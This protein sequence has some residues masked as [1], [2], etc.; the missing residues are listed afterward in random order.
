MS[1]YR[2]IVREVEA[3]RV[4]EAG[5]CQTLHGPISYE[6]VDYLIEDPVTKDR[7]P[8]KEH[9]FIRRYEPVLE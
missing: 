7:W 8:I 2:T 6:A 1:R 3:V 9:E 4:N 5:I